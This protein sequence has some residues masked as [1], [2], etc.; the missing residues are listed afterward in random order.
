MKVKKTKEKAILARARKPIEA[1]ADTGPRRV[2]RTFAGRWRL[3]AAVG[4]AVIV[5]GAAVGGY[6]WYRNDRENRAARAYARVSEAST[7]RVKEAV[8]KAG[9]AGKVDEKKLKAEAL[10]DLRGYVGRYENT[11]AGRA[12]ACEL[13][14]LYF[15]SGKYKEARSYFAAVE[16]TG[17]GL[18]RNLAAKGVADCDKA[19]GDY[20][21]ARAKYEKLLDEV[22]ENFPEVPVAMALADCYQKNGKK[23]EALKLYRHVLD[24]HA[25][26]PYAPE[27]AGEVGKLE[28]LAE[29][30]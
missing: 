1:K 12:A 28:A 22:G 4:G 14:G 11:G 19:L 5:A 13:A 18:E 16:K 25:G 23:K 6:F 10:K 24:Y 29:A 26:S 2:L 21:K 9:P 20:K 7:E 3:F 15:E 30:G 8:K 17:A 27:A